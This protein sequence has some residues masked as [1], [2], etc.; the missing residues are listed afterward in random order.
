[1]YNPRVFQLL[2]NVKDGL[3]CIFRF[4]RFCFHIEYAKNVCVPTASTY[5]GIGRHDGN[6][7]KN[8]LAP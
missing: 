5:I 1:M 2:I 4:N 8:V 3:G 6:K 7:S